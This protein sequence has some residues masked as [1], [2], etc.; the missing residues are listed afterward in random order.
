MKDLNK[1]TEPI[2][3]DLQYGKLFAQVLASTCL[4]AQMFARRRRS[5]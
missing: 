3:Q 1:K 2:Y 5:S 4:A